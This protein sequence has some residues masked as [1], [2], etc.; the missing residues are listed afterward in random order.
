MHL[1]IHY[2]QDKLKYASLGCLTH[3]GR[4]GRPEA[5]CGETM[6]CQIDLI[7]APWLVFT[8]DPTMRAKRRIL[9]VSPRCYV[10]V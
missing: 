8:E 1:G 9:N 6:A 3:I 5:S 2:Y 7:R 10:A 4:S